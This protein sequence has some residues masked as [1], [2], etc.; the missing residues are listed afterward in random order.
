MSILAR[1]KAVRGFPLLLLALLSV[2]PGFAGV[3]RAIQEK[4]KRDYE[5]KALFMKVPIFSEKQII[6]VRGRGGRPEQVTGGIR[7]KV[8]DQVRVMAVDFGGD[9]IKFKLG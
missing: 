3:S 8:G 5:N 9:E 7:F 4:Y 2:D 6:A 1:L